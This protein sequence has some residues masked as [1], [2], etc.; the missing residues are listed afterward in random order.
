[1]YR[2]D[3][4]GTF[5]EETGE[6]PDISRLRATGSTRTSPIITINK[7]NNL[8][9]ANYNTL[10]VNNHFWIINV[11]D[12]NFVGIPFARASRRGG[13]FM[14][15]NGI[16]GSDTTPSYIDTDL[17][18]VT[19]ASA[20]STDEVILGFL[21]NTVHDPFACY[22]V[23]MGACGT[24]VDTCAA[25]T[26]NTTAVSDTAGH[27]Q[28]QCDGIGGGFS[29]VCQQAKQRCSAEADLDHCT[30]PESGSGA[31]LVS[32]TC[33]TGYAGSCSYTCSDGV[34]TESSNGCTA[35]STVTV[36]DGSACL[37]NLGALTLGSITSVSGNWILTESL[38]CTVNGL[39]GYNFA[40]FYTFTLSAVKPCYY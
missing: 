30:L 12:K 10:S 35:I 4:T 2:R 16:S 19:G 27:H 5:H 6:F 29:R 34:W 13:G 22:G 23:V 25:G 37:H 36:A 20:L 7:T 3:N 31:A 18:T 15:W 1:M 14:T 33:T 8:G 24:E 40:R 28:W 17:L 21:N 11:S 39:F 9:Y 32:G 38:S 26:V